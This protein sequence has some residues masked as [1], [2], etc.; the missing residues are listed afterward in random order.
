MAKN[1]LKG[2][3]D[4]IRKNMDEDDL[5]ILRAEMNK[6]YNMHLIPD[7]NV[8]DCNRVIDMLDEYGEENDLVEGW[9][10]NYEMSDILE[11]LY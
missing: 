6:C 4:Y 2:A 9:W 8:M 5:A 3:I 10:E 7:D 11:K 1:I